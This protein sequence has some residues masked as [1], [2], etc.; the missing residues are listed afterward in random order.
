[1]GRPQHR[2]R[3]TSALNSTT[4]GDGAGDEVRETV[5]GEVRLTRRGGRDEEQARQ[6]VVFGFI[7]AAPNGR[8]AGEEL[9]EDDGGAGIL[10]C[11]GEIA[12]SMLPD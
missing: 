1:M 10:G 8:G 9:D 12:M 6:S 2:V 3:K 11:S 4:L 7:D 5:L